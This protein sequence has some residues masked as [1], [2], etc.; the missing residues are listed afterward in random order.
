MNVTN[1]LANLYVEKNS[2]LR[3]DTAGVTWE[4][5]EGELEKLKEDLE[6]QEHK[7]GVFKQTYVGMLPEQLSTNLSILEGY[8]RD[9][10]AAQVSK[11][12]AE[13]RKRM[14]QDMAQLVIDERNIRSLADKERLDA[15]LIVR[16]S[17]F[18]SLL[19][20][21][22]AKES[23]LESL[24]AEYKETY[25]D[26]VMMKRDIKV[27]EDRLSLLKEDGTVGAEKTRNKETAFLPLYAGETGRVIQATEIELDSLVA[28]E[29]LLDERIR[30]YDRRI[31][32]TPIVEQELSA[33]LRDYEITKHNY[34]ALL[35]KKQNATISK[36]FEAREV[37]ERFRL[38]DPANLPQDPIKPNKAKVSLAGLFLS[39]AAGIGAAFVRDKFDRS[40]RKPV[41][42]ERVTGA[43]VLAY[44]P[45]F[46]EE[47][48]AY[49]KYGG[50]GKVNEKS[51]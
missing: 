8:R 2:K 32:S 36:S 49:Y 5:L 46:N 50:K 37:G 16:D 21:L 23:Q 10:Q 43:P 48:A 18:S 1:E 12:T 7:I 17:P 41:E 35:D 28:R 39:L 51:R 34:D 42:L 47:V 38:L 4:F 30:S 44:I 22:A 13:E 25:P 14:Y 19:L 31:E 11:K 20:Q 26:V 40:I 9:M 27:L 6:R 3:I 45:D 33:L 29:K 15:S 24:R